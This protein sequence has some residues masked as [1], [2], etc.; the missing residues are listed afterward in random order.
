[1][2]D[3]YIKEF[4]EAT[5]PNSTDALLIDQGLGAYKYVQ[6]AN[7]FNKAGATYN[8][9]GTL[10]LGTNTIYDGNM[11]GNWAMNSGNV[12]GM[13]TLGCGAITSSGDITFGDATTSS[14]K[15]NSASTAFAQGQGSIIDLVPYRDNVSSMIRIRPTGTA[16]LMPCVLLNT[17]NNSAAGSYNFF[18]GT[19]INTMPNYTTA[20]IASTVS[21]LSG[22]DSLPIGFLVSNTTLG[23]FSAM[24]IQNTGAV[25]IS[26]GG[27]TVAGKIE[28]TSTASDSIKTAGQVLSAGFRLSALQT[29]PANAGATGTLGE[30]RIVDGYI[31]VCTAT[32]T[33]KRAEIATW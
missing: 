11:T 14:L 27:L 18:L 19:G 26:V 8:V 10:D 5:T 28:T 16:T 23:R 6:I 13:G 4:S 12:S 30:I 3:K 7:L 1:M 24:T 33:W 22:A 25:N 31:Y 20:W 2:V 15:F 17:T 21:G 29:A 9:A 32:N